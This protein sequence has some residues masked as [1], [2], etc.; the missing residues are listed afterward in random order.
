[1]DDLA[2]R[3]LRHAAQWG[4]QRVF[5]P[6]ATAATAQL[7]EDGLG[8]LFECTCHCRCPMC[9]KGAETGIFRDLGKRSPL[10]CARGCCYR[11]IR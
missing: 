4:P 6:Q 7:V 8:E 1:M 2:R 3:F 10:S 9:V 11:T 5:S